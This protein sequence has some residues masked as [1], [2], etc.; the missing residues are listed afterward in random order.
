[1]VKNM[2]KIEYK[3]YQPWSSF[4]MYIRLPKN[5]LDE[6]IELTDT[7]LADKE[8]KNYGH[9]LAGQIKNQVAIVPDIFMLG[10]VGKYFSAAYKTYMNELWEQ[11]FPV[12]THLV[13]KQKQLESP[14]NI[15]IIGAWIV[16][17][18]DHEYNPRHLHTECQLS[19]IMYLK[20][21]EYL[22]DIKEPKHGK[23][24][25]MDGAVQFTS[26][27]EGIFQK[28]FNSHLTIRPLPGDFFIFPATQF[29]QVYPFRT[30][31]GKGER[32]S[33]SMNIEFAY[34]DEETGEGTYGS[35][36]EYFVDPA[37]PAMGVA[38]EKGISK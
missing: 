18:R 37:K 26:S 24:E 12:A 14:N 25:S 28:D 22:P 36:I 16:S 38:I 20:I 15:S 11:A 23:D 13:G 4:I 21:P 29:H 32:R 7:I 27:A 8:A 35:D 30:P 6:M 31:D 34:I 3:K 1:V 17:Q 2:E 33:V 19:S 9:A 10:E 5:I